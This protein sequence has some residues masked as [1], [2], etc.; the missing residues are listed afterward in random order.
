MDWSRKGPRG[1]GKGEREVSDGSP[2]L[3]LG[4][5]KTPGSQKLRAGEGAVGGEG[6]F[7]D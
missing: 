5:P 6:V 4:S 7:C 3:A 1:G 2:A